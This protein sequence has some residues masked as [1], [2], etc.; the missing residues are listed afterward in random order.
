LS[1][2]FTEHRN[3]KNKRV[4]KRKANPHRGRIVPICGIVWKVNITL[5]R[6]VE[7]GVAVTKLLLTSCGF[8]TESIRSTFLNLVDGEVSHLKASIITT[9]SPKKENNRFAQKAKS[10]FKA[11]GIQN[12]DFIDLE[13][14]NPELLTQKDVIYISGGNPFNLLF[15]TIKS[16]AHDIIKKLAAQNVVI[17]GVSAG[18]LLLGPNIKIVQ[19]FTPEMN[20]LNMNDFTALDITDKLIFPHYDREDLFKDDAGRT[21]EERIR[22]FETLENCEVTKLNDDQSTLILT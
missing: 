19:F 16:G 10:D 14:E 21:I 1:S 17:V 7:G 6:P 13:F 15:H 3:P 5:I 8:H 9:A 4:F 18:A 12:V 22:E 20:T 11:M 2:L